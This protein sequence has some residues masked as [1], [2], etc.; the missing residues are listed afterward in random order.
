MYTFIDIYVCVCIHMHIYIY[1]QKQRE[2]RESERERESQREE[3]KRTLCPGSLAKTLH[4]RRLAMGLLI[5]KTF[6]GMCVRKKPV[7]A[8]V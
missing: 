3:N 7:P 2:E 1:V 6:L 5:V 4:V 8:T